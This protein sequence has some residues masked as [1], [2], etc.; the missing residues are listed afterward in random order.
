MAAP[1][2]ITSCITRARKPCYYVI[3]CTLCGRTKGCHVL[4]YF[5]TAEMVDVLYQQY[6]TVLY[7]IS[8]IWPLSQ[9]PYKGKGP[10]TQTSGGEKREVTKK[11]TTKMRCHIID[12]IPPVSLSQWV[13]VYEPPCYISRTALPSCYNYCTRYTYYCLMYIGSIVIV[14]GEMDENG[15]Y[16]ASYNDIFG[17]IPANFIQEIEL[18]D[19]NLISRLINQ[20]N[21]SYN[22]NGIVA[23]LII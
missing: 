20:V 11:A 23:I 19:Q 3:Y 14:S 8:L 16:N 1:H 13:S 12:C 4:H 5:R 6:Q 17:I 21:S 2:E 9:R 10:P 22:C 18:H 15:Y 7:E